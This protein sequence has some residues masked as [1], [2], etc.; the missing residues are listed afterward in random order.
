MVRVVLIMVGW[1]GTSE[2]SDVEERSPREPEPRRG[3][4]ARGRRST[5]GPPEFTPDEPPD[6]PQARKGK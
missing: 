6:A 4:A 3:D 5:N 2:R 1:F